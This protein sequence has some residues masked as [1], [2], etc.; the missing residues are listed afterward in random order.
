MSTEHTQS[1]WA[2]EYSNDV[3]PDDDYFIEFFEILTTDCEVLARV[4]KE[5]DARLM[6]SAPDLLEALKEARATLA[7]ALKSTAPDW[8]VTEGDVKEH[9]SIKKMDAVIAKATGE[10]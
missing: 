1:P 8:F 5:S 4:E 6:A 2:F 7:T 10:K 9:L 3:G